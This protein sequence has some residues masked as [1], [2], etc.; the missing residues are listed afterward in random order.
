MV[1]NVFLYSLGPVMN[2]NTHGSHGSHGS[3]NWNESQRMSRKIRYGSRN[4]NNHRNNNANYDHN[5]SHNNSGLHHTTG[6][7]GNIPS[8]NPIRN[9][10]QPNN[11]RAS[12]L[13]FN[14]LFL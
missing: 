11:V 5:N 14:V 7:G 2:N 4:S 10:I 9:S 3:G 8:L 12:V 1:T 6:G 13:M